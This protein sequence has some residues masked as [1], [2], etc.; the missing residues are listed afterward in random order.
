MI[1]PIQLL[2][3]CNVNNILGGGAGHFGGGVG[4]KA[5][6][7]NGQYNRTWPTRLL[8]ANKIYPSKIP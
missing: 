6:P 5:Q 1:F 4:G 2:I 3:F 7:D 8:K